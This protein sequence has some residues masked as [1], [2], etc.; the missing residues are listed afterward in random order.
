ME[1]RPTLFS[2]NLGTYLRYGE[3]G[4]LIVSAIG[5]T[6]FYSDSSKGIQVILIGLSSLSTVYFLYAFTL[7]PH[8][9]HDIGSGTSP[10]GAFDLMPT[11]IRKVVYLASSVSIV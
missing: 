5:L 6:L 4:F 2:Q 11:I 9:V 1:A 7:P 10:R 8:A 3:I